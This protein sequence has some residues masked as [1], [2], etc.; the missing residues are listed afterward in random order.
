MTSSG[1]ESVAS[2]VDKAMNDNSSIIDV[3]DEIGR[4]SSTDIDTEF[5][6]KLAI[7]RCRLLKSTIPQNFVH[8]Y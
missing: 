2:A 4:L 6:E 5:Q 3:L 7:Q 1:E 8:L